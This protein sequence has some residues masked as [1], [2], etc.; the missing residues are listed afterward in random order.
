MTMS[1]H[2]D[3]VS[4]N[5]IVDELIILRSKLVQALLNDVIAI[6]IL[7]QCDNRKAESNDDGMDLDVAFRVS[8]SRPV[9]DIREHPIGLYVPVCE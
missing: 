1:S 7:N 3:A 4:R 5:S 2:F 6:Q 9:S 8:L